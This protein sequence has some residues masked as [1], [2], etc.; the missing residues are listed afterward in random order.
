M[1]STEKQIIEQ[2][3]IGIT[4]TTFSGR[5]LRA[6]PEAYRLLG[7]DPT[8]KVLDVTTLYPYPEQRAELVEDV[9][10]GRRDKRRQVVLYVNGEPAHF[11]SM[12]VAFRTD[13]GEDGVILSAFWR[14]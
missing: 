10:A 3:P 1:K 5:L 14:V 4:L 2:L 9:K 6:N 11:R 8:V 7:I 12:N 13:S